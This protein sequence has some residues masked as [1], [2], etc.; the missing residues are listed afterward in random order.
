[1]K[2]NLPVKEKSN[3]KS[4]NSLRITLKNSLI[5]LRFRVMKKILNRSMKRII[6]TITN[7]CKNINKIVITKN[8]KATSS[9]KYDNSN[10]F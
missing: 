3:S 2:V 7:S 10:M 4:K 8:N 1:M 5:K 6:R 9:I